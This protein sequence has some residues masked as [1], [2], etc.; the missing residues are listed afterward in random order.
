SD[1]VL[2]TAV[3]VG[4]PGETKDDFAELLDFVA[5][6]GFDQLGCFPFSSEEGTAAARLDGA[7]DPATVAARQDRLMHEQA[8]IHTERLHA[9]VGREL[10][11]LVDGPGQA[12]TI[13]APHYGQAFEVDNLTLVTGTAPAGSRLRVRI[14]GTRDYDL[15]AEALA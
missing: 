2:R 6:T 1:V 7:L 4:F 9:W 3:I 15:L 13:Q 5:T 14:T 10:D 8:R 12:G 11:V